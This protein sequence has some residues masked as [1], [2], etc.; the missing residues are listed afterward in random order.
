MNKTIFIAAVLAVATVVAAG[1]AVLPSSVQ[2]AQANPCA[3][4]V[5]VH[6]DSESEGNGNNGNDVTTN[7]NDENDERE[8]NF[9]GPVELD[10][11]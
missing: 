4:E 8:C 3:T 7:T 5:E 10:E 9:V 1:L 2:D 6:A 11:D